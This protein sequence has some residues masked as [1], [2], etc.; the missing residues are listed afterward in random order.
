MLKKK[1]SE[2]QAKKIIA[3]TVADMAFEGL[4]CD[5][6]D[7]ERGHRILCGEAT[8]DSEIKKIIAKYKSIGRG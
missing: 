6:E 4:I 2:E 7:I 3:Q 5:D 8:A 1:L